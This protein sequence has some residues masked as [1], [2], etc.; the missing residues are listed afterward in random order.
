MGRT[1]TFNASKQKMY[2]VTK[3]RTANASPTVYCLAAETETG[4][5]WFKE[6]KRMRNRELQK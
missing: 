3:E 5:C 1:R 2:Q 4:N 6:E